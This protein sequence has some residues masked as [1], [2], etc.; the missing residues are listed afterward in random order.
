[1]QNSKNVHFVKMK[2]Y[3]CSFG[4]NA[5]VSFKDLDT[6]LQKLEKTCS[7]Y[8]LIIVLMTTLIIVTMTTTISRILYRFRWKL[9]YM[10]YVAKEKYKGDFDQFQ[11]RRQNSFRFYAFFH[12]QTKIEGILLSLWNLWKKITVWVC[13]FIIGTLF[14]GRG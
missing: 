3:T 10:Y 1:M 13:A 2:D 8:T 4:R 7:S 14:L 11:F 9:R 5:T 6:I 12:T